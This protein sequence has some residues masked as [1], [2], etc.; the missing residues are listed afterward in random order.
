MSNMKQVEHFD[1]GDNVIC[2][3]CGKDFTNSD[4]VGGIEFVS[5]ACCPD[6]TPTILKSAKKYNEES[7]IR[8]RCPKD[9]S[10]AQW[11]REDLRNG[12]PGWMTITSF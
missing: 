11:V 5:K 1:L 9:K 3:L 4:A 7:H 8:S 10:F 6:W 12:E 2:D